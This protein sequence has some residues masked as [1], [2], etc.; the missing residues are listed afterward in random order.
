MNTDQT[1]D[2]ALALQAQERSDAL[3]LEAHDVLAGA[4]SEERRTF[5]FRGEVHVAWVDHAGQVHVECRGA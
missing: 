3:Q 1:T 4:A 5:D 2:E